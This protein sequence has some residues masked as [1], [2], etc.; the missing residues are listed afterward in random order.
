MQIELAWYFKNPTSI[1][2]CAVESKKYPNIS[3]V[4]LPPAAIQ[5]TMI[6]TPDTSY[7]VNYESNLYG[8]N[9]FKILKVLPELKAV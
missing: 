3:R 9:T 4:I 8:W 1:G 5:H 7:D 6:F 2:G